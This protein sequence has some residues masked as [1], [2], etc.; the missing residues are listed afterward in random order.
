MLVYTWFKIDYAHGGT[1][2]TQKESTLKS[3]TTSKGTQKP[4]DKTENVTSAKPTATTAAGD[5]TLPKEVGNTNTDKT[6]ATTSGHGQGAQKVQPLPDN[7]TNGGK[8]PGKIGTTAPSFASV[9]G[10]KGVDVDAEQKSVSSIASEYF[11]PVK[12]AWLF[13]WGCARG[14]GGWCANGLWRGEKAQARNK[15]WKEGTGNAVEK[16]VKRAGP[17]SAAITQ[18]EET[19]ILV[20]GELYRDGDD[21]I[22]SVFS[23]KEMPGIV[24]V[25]FLQMKKVK[26][27][28]GE[29][30]TRKLVTGLM[31]FDDPDQE[32][33]VEPFSYELEKFNEE[34]GKRLKTDRLPGM[35]LTD[36]DLAKA[37]PKIWR[38][39]REAVKQ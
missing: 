38:L 6:K 25:V 34:V 27:E 22:S 32:R 1:S 8:L 20:N 13:V 2:Q 16:A 14:F 33:R 23:I 10:D 28:D 18:Y 4:G 21:E 31:I 3:E 5:K 29:E 35:E 15:N 11:K 36:E 39:Q 17:D 37:A 7:N 24:H 30:K 12:G 19:D 26:G 9:A